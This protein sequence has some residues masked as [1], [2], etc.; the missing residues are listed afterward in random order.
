MN[1]TAPQPQNGPAEI[2]AAEAGG[3]LTVDLG[4]L[5]ANWRT[6]KK[7]AGECSAV[8][9]ADAYGIGIEQAVSA[10]SGAGCRTFF[11]AQLSEAVRVRA[12]AA[13]AAVYVLN[14]LPPGT[15]TTFVRHS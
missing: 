7:A 14:G 5:T 10:L 13:E 12:A 1:G 8:V 6:L 2:P 9:K 4:A 3:I 15:A 11:V